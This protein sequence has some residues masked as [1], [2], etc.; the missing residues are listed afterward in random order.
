MNAWFLKILF[1]RKVI[2]PQAVAQIE[3]EIAQQP[4][5]QISFD[6]HLVFESWFP[7]ECNYAT[8]CGAN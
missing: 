1:P 7:E 4:V 8:G 5:A 2:A 6:K 3:N